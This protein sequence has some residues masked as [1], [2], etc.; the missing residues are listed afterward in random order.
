MSKI[1]IVTGGSSGIGKAVVTRLI[2][3]NYIVY[4]LSRR[5]CEVKDFTHIPTD[6]TKEEEV[7]AAIA[8]VLAE[9][10]H[11]DLLINNAGF[12]VSGAIE[13]TTSDEA[14]A[15][16]EVNLFGMDNVT[17]AVIP[18]MRENR[19][20]RIVS[21]SSVAALVGIPFQAWYSVSKSAVLTYMLSLSNELRP[22]GVTTCTILPG[23]VKTGFTGAR[24]KNVQGDDL[25]EG[26]ISKSVAG[27]EHDESIGMTPDEVAGII[28]KFAL[29]KKSRPMVV[30]GGIYR[31]EG[32][33]I[34]LLPRRLSNW[35]V[36]NMYAK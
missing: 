5:D 26:R 15:Q 2:Q 29:K 35:I 25:Y 11:I 17:R 13:M 31:L 22:F 7:K 16:M 8:R 6:I 34:K 10:G 23:D 24:K 1:A 14:H 12:G 18:S 21:V 32:V 27:M 30:V 9:Q 4:E 28:V 33:L 19:A 36:G 20:G 3:E